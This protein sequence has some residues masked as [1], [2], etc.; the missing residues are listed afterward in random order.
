MLA[1]AVG[2][3]DCLREQARSHMGWTISQAMRDNAGQFLE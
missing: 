3:T 2:L 1:K